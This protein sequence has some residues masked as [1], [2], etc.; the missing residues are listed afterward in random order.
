MS[1][2]AGRAEPI[3]V[4]ACVVRSSDGLVLMAKRTP[5]QISPGF[6]ELPGGKVDPGETPAR[7]AIRE[8]HEEVGLHAESTRPWISYEHA[9]PL[10]RLRLT[11][12][13][14]DRWSGEPHGREGQRLAWVDPAAPAVAPILPSNFRVLAAVALPP[15]YPTFVCRDPLGAA[16][17]LAGLRKAFA[18]GTRLACLSAAAMSPDQRVTLAR[19]ANAVARPF[20]AQIL[21][22]GSALEARRA[23]A[24][25]IQSL[26]RE[27][28]L[29]TARPAVPLWAATC[30]DGADLDRAIQLGADMAVMEPMGADAAGEGRGYDDLAARSPIPLYARAAGVD[31]AMMVQGPAAHVRH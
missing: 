31:M 7:A 15:T 18:L 27:L 23:G 5:C 22:T 4:A 1:R 25:G 19:R 16:A 26:A 9:F 3:D 29:L 13:L 14:V 17:T 8:L 12:F 6:W 2:V 30:R 11:F 10:R 21:I 28:I 20:G 24:A